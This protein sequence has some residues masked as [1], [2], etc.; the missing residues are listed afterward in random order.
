MG[1]KTN[2]TLNCL[3]PPI[4]QVPQTTKY[5]YFVSLNKIYTRYSVV[6]EILGQTKNFPSRAQNI[7]VS[8]PLRTINLGE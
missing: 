5:L 8:P 7:K 3:P 1:Q 2:T 6:N 4:F